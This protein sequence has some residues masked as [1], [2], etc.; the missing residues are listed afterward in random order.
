MDIGIGLAELI[1]VLASVIIPL[2]PIFLVLL[3]ALLVIFRITPGK[4]AVKMDAEETRMV[5]EIQQNL[6]RMEKRIESLETL[7]L[8]E[9]NPADHWKR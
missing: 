8:G 4:N 6:G 5:Q 9:H 3:L 1:V 7:M 2:A